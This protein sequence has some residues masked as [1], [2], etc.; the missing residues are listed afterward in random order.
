MQQALIIS[1]IL[2]MTHYTPAAYP[3]SFDEALDTFLELGFELNPNVTKSML[4]EL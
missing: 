2:I 4:S 3:P 1:L